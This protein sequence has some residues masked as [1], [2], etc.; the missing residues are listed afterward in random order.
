M[1]IVLYI[2]IALAI[3]ALITYGASCLINE[4]NEW[5][6]NSDAVGHIYDIILDI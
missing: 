3:G 4:V 1:K 6:Q 5:W 2:L